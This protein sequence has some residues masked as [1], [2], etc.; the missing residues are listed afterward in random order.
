MADEI[1]GR[2][3][4]CERRYDLFRRPSSGGMLGHIKMQ[5]LAT[6]VFQEDKYEQ[7]PHGNC[8]HS[9]EIDRDHLADMIVQEGPAGLVRRRRS[10]R[11]RRDTL[12]SE[13]AMPSICSSP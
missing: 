2:L 9:K 11:R 4:V 12:R 13:M 3:S 6:I 10:L 1:L 8:R 5:H 7:H